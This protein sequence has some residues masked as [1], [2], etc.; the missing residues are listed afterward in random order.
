MTTV[1]RN[2]LSLG[3]GEWSVSSD[4]HTDLVCLGMGSCVAFVAHDPMAQVGGM[5]HM[6]LP[7]ST[8]GRASAA[9]PAK[10]VDLAIPLVLARLEA[11]GAVRGRLRIHLVGGAQMLQTSLALNIGERNVAAADK[12]LGALRLRLTTRDV[13][14]THG[15]TVRLSVATG[16]LDIRLAVSNKGAAQVAA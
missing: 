15:R 3:L 11:V 9:A 5:A 7:D 8:A 14:G 12:V 1:A 6:V 16:A 2:D 4:L 10:F 13:G